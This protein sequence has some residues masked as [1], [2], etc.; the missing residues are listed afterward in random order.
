MGSFQDTVSRL[1]A[2]WAEQGCVVLPP[3][4]VQV[5]TGTMMPE[6]FLRLLGP[7]P[8][9]G[10]HLLSSRR[11]WDG[12]YARNNLRLGKHF[13]FQ[14]LLKPPV[15]QARE[16]FVDSLQAAGIDLGLHDLQLRPMRFR[17]RALAVQGIGWHARLDGIKVAHI[18]YLQEAAGRGLEPVSLEITYGVERLA[19]VEQGVSGIDDVTWSAGVSYG[20]V[21]QR[22]EEDFSHYH[23]EVADVEVLRVQ[24]ESCLRAARQSLERGLVLPSY[25]LVLQASH[26]LQTVLFRR[27]LTTPEEAEWRSAIRELATS[28]AEQYL[29]RREGL[30]FPLRGSFDNAVTGEAEATN[31][32]G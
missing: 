2:F 18:V 3:L 5:G 30:D 23:F 17:V 14:V 29:A 25:E 4:D 6:V 12:R 11:P 20:E 9:R 13:Q 21:R 15:A 8:W 27:G 26:L 19:M 1:S 16:V 32:E 31:D 10:A 28:C 22:D 7:E 24:L